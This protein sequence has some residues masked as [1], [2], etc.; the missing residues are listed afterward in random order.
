MIYDAPEI[1]RMLSNEAERF[2]SFYLRH[3]RK[4]GQSEWRAADIMDS[5]PSGK[6]GKSFV[7]TLTGSKAGLWYENSTGESGHIIDVICKQKGVAF[8]DA[9][10]I[11]KEF[12]GIRE[13]DNW[14]EFQKKSPAAQKKISS[15]ELKP[16]AEGSPVWNYLV[17]E[18]GIK[19]EVVSKYGVCENAV[20][21]WFRDCQKKLPA[22]AYPVY[23]TTERAG[24]SELV[25]IKYLAV[26]R[27]P[28]GKK[29]ISQ[30]PL[31]TNHLIFMN[32]I[33]RTSRNVVICEGEI[34]ALTMAGAGLPAVSV[35]AGAHGDRQ[36]GQPHANNEWLT[37]DYI[38]LAGF[39]EIYLCF[40]SDDAGR[41]AERALF[42]RLGVERTKVIRI[43]EVDENVKDPNSYA[44]YCAENGMDVDA[45]LKKLVENA[46]QLNPETIKNAVQYKQQLYD[47]MFPSGNK[48]VGWVLPNCN[49][50][51]HFMIR[52]GE[53]SDI[54]G[55]G[56]HGKS[57]WL[58]DLI[59]SLCME[60]DEKAVIGSFEIPPARTLLSMIRQLS[61][62]RRIS[63]VDDRGNETPDVALF[64]EA[65]SMLNKH[66]LF[67]DFV[68]TAEAKSV[69]EAYALAARMYGVKFFVIDSLMCM[70]IEEVDSQG[71]KEFMNRLREFVIKYGV[72]VFLV[73]HSR[74]PS[75]KKREETYIPWKHDI[76]G[77][78]HISNLAWNVIT[79]WRNVSKDIRY[80][81]AVQNMQEAEAEFEV[82]RSESARQKYSSWK[83]K[84][85]Q[86]YA[87]NDCVVAIRKQRDGTGELPL[88]QLWFDPDSHQYRNKPNHEI[89]NYLSDRKQE[90][91]HYADEEDIDI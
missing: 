38:W 51:E 83:K 55:F 66:I 18:R 71:Q 49:F 78:V 73:C 5:M 58:N 12:L 61:G 1:K 40:D 54:T 76:L 15:A 68:G 45:E 4:Y 74:K 41:N 86:I 14:R 19:P 7:V 70:D 2:C 35:P 27:S 31:G 64:D 23:K 90:R 39:D 69:L 13:E 29:Y 42:Y 77:S 63:I 91:K 30:H 25:N 53:V 89:R 9:L 46:T 65:V 17:H 3:G 43:P 82:S 56:G 16:A 62:R 57:E 6:P 32:R 22:I 20:P 47:L 85:E 52:G 67:Y 44:E 80:Q 33:P 48:P 21:V 84:A 50:G 28:E 11:A 87:E 36:D 24:D 60:N 10:K 75:E 81:E 88:K 34:D 59:I 79:V 26:E 72:H 37:N 8:R